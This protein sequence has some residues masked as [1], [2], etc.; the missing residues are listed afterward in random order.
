QQTYLI[1]AT[2]VHCFCVICVKCHVSI[3]PQIFCQ[4][5]NISFTISRAHVPIEKTFI[6]L[7]IQQRFIVFQ[8]LHF[9]YTLSTTWHLAHK[10]SLYIADKQFPSRDKSNFFTVFRNIHV[11]YFIFY[12]V[13]SLFSQNVI[14]SK[15]DLGFMN[16]FALDI[17]EIKFII[18]FKNHFFSIC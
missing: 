16:S 13:F 10:L 18:F 8:P 17:I 5:L 3:T 6:C 9:S 11:G 14:L 12:I 2:C 15:S 7:I 4:L 1:A